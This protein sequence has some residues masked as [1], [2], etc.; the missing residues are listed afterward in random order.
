[1][2]EPSSMVTQP[3][4]RELDKPVC[5]LIKMEI[6]Y[7]N[8]SKSNGTAESLCRKLGSETRKEE[9]MFNMCNKQTSWNLIL[10]EYDES[11]VVV[12]VRTKWE[13]CATDVFKAYITIP[14]Y[15]IQQQAD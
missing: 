6:E 2:M 7:R 1:M 4:T 15:D 12:V 8:N 14:I 5:L 3:A 10:F 9:I 13:I 11:R